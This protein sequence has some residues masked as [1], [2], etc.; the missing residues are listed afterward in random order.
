MEKKLTGACWN[1]KL[2]KWRSK[3]TYDYTTIHL[4]YF[5]TQEEA[6]EAFKKKYETLYNKA[7]EYKNQ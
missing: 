7:Y 4:G 2:G 3:I 5:L 6:H 1:K